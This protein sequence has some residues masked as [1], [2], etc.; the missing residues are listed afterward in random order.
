MRFVRFEV[1]GTDDSGPE[2]LISGK[3]L[4]GEAFE[5]PFQLVRLQDHG[6]SSHV[7][8]GSK[9]IAFFPFGDGKRGYV[10][11][12]ESDEHRPKNLKEGET[13][14]YDR[15]GNKT[16][17]KNEDGVERDLGDRDETIKG[18]KVTIEASEE[19]IVKVSGMILRVR[20]GRIDLG[21][22]EAPHAVATQAG[23]STKVFAVI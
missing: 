1:T 17:Y 21:A 9:A 16:T 7:P 14:I 3:A 13:A 11:G 5:P 2:Q 8:N 15:K 23:F 10:F 12:V 20:P 18:K 22:M 6:V 19:L 4:Q